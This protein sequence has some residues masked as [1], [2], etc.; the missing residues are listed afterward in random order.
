MTT[1]LSSFGS[2]IA[3]PAGGGTNCVVTTPTSHGFNFSD[4]ASCGLATSTDRQTG[5]PALGALANNGG[6]TATQLPGSASPLID[7]IPLASCQVD[8]AAGITTDQRGVTRPQ[9]SGC[10][11]GAVE[12]IPALTATPAFTG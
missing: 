6:P 11:I 1:T 9:G 2:V 3:L 12:V 8:G 5:N 7:A 10:D 4:D